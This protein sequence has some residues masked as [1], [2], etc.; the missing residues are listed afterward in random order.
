MLRLPGALFEELSF[1]YLRH[2]HKH[3]E[4]VIPPRE[5][6]AFYQQNLFPDARTVVHTLD[7]NS[8]DGISVPDVIVIAPQRKIM[9]IHE[10][11]LDPA[12]DNLDR[13]FKALQNNK[14][15]FP[16]RFPNPRF[17]VVAPQGT[18][19]AE[20]EYLDID[21]EPLPLT[22]RQFRDFLEDIYYGSL[23][24]VVEGNVAGVFDIR[25]RMGY[26]IQ[27]HLDPLLREEKL[28]YESVKFLFG[29]FGKDEGSYSLLG[30]GTVY[31]HESS[32][33]N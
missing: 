27:R 32:R 10:C 4:R 11:T 3:P 16:G 31:T 24:G 6:V 25:D 26:Q 28:P 18:K 22:D 1:I 13:K 8:L 33:H 15:R 9:V 29:R 14:K 23:L 17:A 7:R 21:V 5:V 20:S 2:K 12:R 30:S 19:V